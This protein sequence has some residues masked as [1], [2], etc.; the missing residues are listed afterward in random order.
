MTIAIILGVVFMVFA[1]AIFFGAPYLPTLKPQITQALDLMDLEKGQTMIE[2]GSGDGRVMLAA[3]QR[4]W[5]VVGYEIN[6]LLVAFSWLLTIRYRKQVTIIWGDYW[7]KSWP[8]ADGIFVFL[9]DKYMQKFDEH[10]WLNCK[11]PV[12]VVSFAFK[13]PGK[14]IAG[15]NKGMFLYK[16]NH[17]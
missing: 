5:K 3:A 16:Y 4:G 1:F 15:K 2:L 10:V 14:R 8:E 9:L 7:R 11:K 6:P 17:R 12:R 13:I